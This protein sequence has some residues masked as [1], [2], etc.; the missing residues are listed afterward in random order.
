M[1]T[2]IVK[3][4]SFVCSLRYRLLQHP[5]QNVSAIEWAR[6]KKGHYLI[7]YDATGNVNATF[8]WVV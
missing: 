8:I 6:K 5:A 1:V 3:H 7:S 2:F 4:I